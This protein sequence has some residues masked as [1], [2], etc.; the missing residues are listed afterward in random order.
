MYITTMKKINEIYCNK[1]IAFNLDDLEGDE[2]REVEEF[3]ALLESLRSQ[4]L[5][6]PDT[7]KVGFFRAPVDT[8][9]MTPDTSTSLAVDTDSVDAEGG[10]TIDTSETIITQPDSSEEVLNED[11]APEKVRSG[12]IFGG[13]L[14]SIISAIEIGENEK[15]VVFKSL[16]SNLS[17]GNIFKTIFRLVF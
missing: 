16:V 11:T 8:R 4:G 5:P 15:S 3:N 10:L 14:A 6:L 17:I 7:S 1:D 9:I 2:R 12:G 13:A